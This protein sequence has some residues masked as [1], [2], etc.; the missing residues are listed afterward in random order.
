L[1]SPVTAAY[2]P[3]VQRELQPTPTYLDSVADAIGK[4]PLVKLGRVLPDESKANAVL[5]KL[6]MQNP[7]GSV[8]DR[9]AKN[10][11]EMAE[12]D[13][14]ISPDR[15]TIVEYTSGN[16]GIGVSMVCAAKGY[17]CI[18]IMPQLPPMKERYSICRKF[19]ADVHLTCGAKGVAGMKIYCEELIASDPDKYWCPQQF[20]NEDNPDMHFSTTGPEIYEQAGGKVDY[21]ISGVGTGGTVTGVGKF[22]KSKNPNM[23][24][25]AVEP[26]ESRVMVG[27][28]HTKHAIVGIG[29][30]FPAYFIEQMAP[31]QPWAE[32]PRGIIDEFLHA[33]LDEA[34]AWADALAKN[35]GLLVGPSTGAVM[36]VAADVACRPEAQGKNIVIIF[37]SNGIRYVNHPMWGPINKEAAAA[38]PAPPNMDPEPIFR[39]NSADYSS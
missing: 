7:G 6:E 21:L 17:K 29:A 25:I 35:E 26:T 3:V 2:A 8:K 18:I 36:K 28:P 5:A 38:L 4:T 15:T 13:G 24:V 11:I 22:L 32:G 37:P 31:E 39:W 10:M 14:T 27:E 34:M 12:R 9:I 16:T 30:G 23:T 1:S 19:G 33:N 20:Y